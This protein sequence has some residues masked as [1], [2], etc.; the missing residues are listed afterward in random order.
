[1]ATHH[2]YKAT[3]YPITMLIAAILLIALFTP[4]F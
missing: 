4:F 3:T 2:K 1:M